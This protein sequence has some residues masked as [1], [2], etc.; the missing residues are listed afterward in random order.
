MA[1]FFA[2]FHAAVAGEEACVSEGDF[3]GGVVFGECSAEPHD[4]GAGLAGGAAA[5]AAGP[6]IHFAAGVGDFE[7]TE[8]GFSIA[9]GGE[10]FVEGSAVDF[11][12]S[13]AGSDAD[14]SDC[15]L[16]AADAPGVGARPFGGFGCGG[17]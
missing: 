11:D 16:A 8:D 3:E 7:G 17:V 14:A 13:A 4:D 1:V 15:G 5:V 12:F 2:F 10:E 6:D 9:F